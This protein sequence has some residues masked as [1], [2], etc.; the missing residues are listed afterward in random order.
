MAAHPRLA[1]LVEPR[2]LDELTAAAR[3]TARA[4]II[5]THDRQMLSDLGR[6][7]TLRIE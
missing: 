1:G 4:V 2:R 5:A 7:P 6:W 3:T